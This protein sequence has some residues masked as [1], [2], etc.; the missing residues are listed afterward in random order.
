MPSCRHPQTR[1]HDGSPRR[2]APDRSASASPAHSM[3]ISTGRASIG[4]RASA[5]SSP[6]VLRT[7]RQH[8]QHSRALTVRVRRPLAEPRQPA[9]VHQ[10]LPIGLRQHPVADTCLCARPA[11]RFDLRPKHRI[12]ETLLALDI[13]QL[14]RS[15]RAT[16]TDPAHGSPA[17]RPRSSAAAAAA[18]RSTRPRGRNPSTASSRARAG[19]RTPETCPVVVENQRPGMCR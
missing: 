12:L 6:I 2:S 14:R 3:C 9:H 10:Q 8:R 16:P 7:R 17:G 11:G 1:P 18:R 4:S 5:S 15:P 19:S 13:A